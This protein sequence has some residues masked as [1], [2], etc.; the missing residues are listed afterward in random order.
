[1]EPGFQDILVRKLAG[2]LN[3]IGLEVISGRVQGETFLPGIEVKDGRLI[4]DQP[5]LLYPGDLLHEAG[6]LAVMSG[7]M[8]KGLSGNLME[9]G[10]DTALIEVAA[11]AWPYAACLH[12]E[13]DPAIVFHPAG[14]RGKSAALLLGFSLGVYPGA[15][16]LQSV[17]LAATS[18]EARAAGVPLYPHILKWARD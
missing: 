6:H 7:V 15:N 10:A 3:G 9:S 8:K 4:V 1:M 12:L 2:F 14:Y 18:A 16:Q 5:R 13:I 17:G 11:I